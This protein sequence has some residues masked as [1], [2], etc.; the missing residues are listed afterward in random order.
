MIFV[1]IILLVTCVHQSV[2]DATEPT[3]MEVCSQSK[4]YHISMLVTEFLSDSDTCNNR[5]PEVCTAI[6][7]EVGYVDGGDEWSNCNLNYL[8][9]WLVD[10]YQDY[11]TTRQ[12]LSDLRTP[13]YEIDPSKCVI[14]DVHLDNLNPDVWH[15]RMAPPGTKHSHDFKCRGSVQKERIFFVPAGH[16]I[17]E[18]P[19]S[20]FLFGR[21]WLN[22]PH[23]IYIATCL[24]GT[25][26]TCTNTSTCQ[27]IWPLTQQGWT[28]Q[29]TVWWIKWQ[30]IVGHCYPCELGISKPHYEVLGN[31]LCSETVDTVNR[32]CQ[33]LLYDWTLKDRVYC[34]GF[35]Y[36]PMLCGGGAV[37]NPQRTECVCPPG[38]YYNSA[39]I[40]IDCPKAHFCIGNNNPEV[41]PIH[42]YQ[43][44]TGQST[45]LSCLTKNKI[46]RATCGANQMAA[47]CSLAN[48]DQTLTYLTNPECVPC[49]QC[50]N[51]A[52]DKFRDSTKK[53]LD[54][55]DT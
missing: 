2:A 41:C 45:C 33:S 28:N 48:D 20:I 42:T 32:R 29:G 24:P 53:Y 1:I 11:Y 30:Y 9:I 8:N 50:S 36:P 47:Q 54:C 18:Y 34:L 27:Y 49:L 10:W 15:D 25:W 19:P 23:P 21:Y 52:I 16:F 7:N 44:D 17:W 6:F 51:P 35:D 55:Y 39:R 26:L 5:A 38:K 12:I 13:V 37:A 40:C 46:P 14:I 31:P 22:G 43:S 4:I 3:A